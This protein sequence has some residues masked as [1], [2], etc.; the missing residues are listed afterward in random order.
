MSAQPELTYEADLTR[1]EELFHAQVSEYD[2]EG[3]LGKA[4]LAITA[5]FL[6]YR[7][8]M[9]RKIKDAMKDRPQTSEGLADAIVEAYN[10]YQMVWLNTVLPHL[11]SG[12][13]DGLID[14]SV[15]SVPDAVLYQIAQG[16]AYNL[17]EH[18]NEVSA[19]AV[20]SGYQ[21]QL[22]RKVPPARAMERVLDAFGVPPRAMNSL[23]NVWTQD[24]VKISSNVIPFDHKKARAKLVIDQA[25]S[26]R[27]KMIGD[28]E[29]WSVREQAKQIVW[30][31]GVETGAISSQATRR[32]QT[33]KDERVCPTCGPM[34]GVEVLIT[35][36]FDVK[37]YGKTWAPPLH[38]SCRCELKIDFDIAGEL[39]Q[40]VKERYRQESVGKALGSDPYDRDRNGRFAVQEQRSSKPQES[41]QAGH[42]VVSQVLR[43]IRADHPAVRIGA[44]EQVAQHLAETGTL[45]ETMIKNLTLELELADAELLELEANQL[46]QEEKEETDEVTLNDV[47]N[48]VVLTDATQKVTFKD[49]HSDV[50]LSDAHANVT[51]TDTKGVTLTDAQEDKDVKLDEKKEVE[52]DEVKT[53]PNVDP[54]Q[55][56]RLEK[57]MYTYIPNEALSTDRNRLS[58]AVA[59]TD[60]VSQWYN[61]NTNTSVLTDIVNNHWS[62][63]TNSYITDLYEEE[64]NIPYNGTIAISADDLLDEIELQGRSAYIYIDKSTFFDAWTWALQNGDHPTSLDYDVAT[65]QLDNGHTAQVEVPF[66]RIADYYNFINMIEDYA[67]VIGEAD[68]VDNSR[69]EYN[70]NTKGAVTIE[71]RWAAEEIGMHH[72]RSNGT[73]SGISGIPLPH[74]TMYLKPEFMDD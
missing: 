35:E 60:N 15:G 41:R 49:T 65:L 50:K 63:I 45:D 43:E 2:S 24:E 1:A 18:I 33:A 59:T 22:N 54:P 55:I 57:T 56:M 61:Y 7:W 71:G 37:G 62:R 34:N 21:A 16:Y 67:P 73:T 72:L 12:Y 10:S 58:R 31:Y 48:D 53:K 38:P 19:E 26:S 4:A 9:Q 5:A 17:G 20:I 47:R 69:Q 42:S 40:D 32:W 74:K 11:I 27:A 46:M 66:D 39:V 8:Y 36:R 68:Y 52:L 13:A 44:I 70:M 25:V 23:V 64:A 3:N 51:L 29:V 14:V 30:L 6:G 28:N